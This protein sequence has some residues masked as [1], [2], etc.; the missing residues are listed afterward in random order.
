MQRKLCIVEKTKKK[1][2]KDE[3]V[4]NRWAGSTVV[5]Q[6]EVRAADL[7]K[8]GCLPLPAIGFQRTGLLLSKPYL[9]LSS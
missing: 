2:V 3:I 6:T 5:D 4:T 7:A 9:A 8:T 1:E